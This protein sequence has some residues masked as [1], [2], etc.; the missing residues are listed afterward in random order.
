MA[1]L[2]SSSMT[3][4][5]SVVQAEQDYLVSDSNKSLCLRRVYYTANEPALTVE[6]LHGLRALFNSERLRESSVKEYHLLTKASGSQAAATS[7]STECRV[8]GD[9]EKLLSHLG[10]KQRSTAEPKSERAF[11]ACIY[12][13]TLA[14]TA[15]VTDVGTGAGDEFLVVHLSCLRNNIGFDDA[16]KVLREVEAKLQPFFAQVS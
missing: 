1:L 14:V 11:V 4:I 7:A 2:K 13:P 5:Q 6:Y 16:V 9:V 3:P 15:T 10:A 12:H 8:E